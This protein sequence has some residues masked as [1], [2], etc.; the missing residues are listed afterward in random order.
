MFD[1]A[2]FLPNSSSLPHSRSR[3]ISLSLLTDIHMTIYIQVKWKCIV[4]HFKTPYTPFCKYI[5]IHFSLDKTSF[6]IP[7]PF[8]PYRCLSLSLP[9]VATLHNDFHSRQTAQISTTNPT[10]GHSGCVRKEN[11]SLLCCSLCVCAK[12]FHLIN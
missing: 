3:P 5:S 7:P 4:Y 12:V 8:S 6:P 1:I 9:G 2:I 11:R 10:L